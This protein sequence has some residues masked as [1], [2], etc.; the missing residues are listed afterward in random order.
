[1][2][3]KD[4]DK[5]K[6]ENGTYVDKSS[7]ESDKNVTAGE[8]PRSSTGTIDSKKPDCCKY[9][10]LHAAPIKRGILIFICTV[11][12]VSFIV[13]IIIYGV[14]ADRR[15]YGEDHNATM[16]L[17]DLDLDNCIDLETTNVQVGRKYSV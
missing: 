4:T 15:S 2:S 11:I 5:E 14:D 12:A 10:K 8:F 1:M 9:S 16:Q 13:P 17:I 3:A 7:E 6:G